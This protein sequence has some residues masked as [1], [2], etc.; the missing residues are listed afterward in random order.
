MAIEIQRL[1]FVVVAELNSE[2]RESQELQTGRDIDTLLAQ[3]LQQISDVVGEWG[4]EIVLPMGDRF[5][6][7]SLAAKL[8]SIHHPVQE[9]S[10]LLSLHPLP[11][12][13]QISHCPP[14]AASGSSPSGR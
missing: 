12:K 14:P 8:P 5:K 4:S 10:P 11:A 9:R 6:T 1:R 3:D 13:F 7:W 2:E